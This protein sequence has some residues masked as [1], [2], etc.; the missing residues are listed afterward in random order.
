[1]LRNSLFITEKESKE[2]EAASTSVETSH[3]HENA[4]V[5]NILMSD[6]EQAYRE[7]S[8]RP[9]NNVTWTFCESHDSDAEVSSDNAANRPANV[10]T[11]TEPVTNDLPLRFR[12]RDRESKVGDCAL[13]AREH[14]IDGSD[15]GTKDS[16]SHP[17]G[18]EYEESEEDEEEEAKTAHQWQ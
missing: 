7:T 5:P 9:Q 10:I 15:V 6:T 2:V 12:V 17:L 3:L 4:L 13:V 18:L 16:M 1:M 11:E 14:L 8:I